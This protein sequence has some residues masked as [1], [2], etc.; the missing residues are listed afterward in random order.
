MY[1]RNSSKAAIA[2][3]EKEQKQAASRK[4]YVDSSDSDL[5]SDDSEGPTGLARLYSGTKKLSDN[6]PPRRTMKMVSF[7][8]IAPGAGRIA[9]GGI[10]YDQQANE[11]AIE[12]RRAKARLLPSMTQLHKH[13]LSWPYEG[14]AD[15]PPNLQASNLIRIPD[16][17][18]DCDEYI[19]TLE[20]LLLLESWAQFQRAKEENAFSE[21][22]EA[23][24]D[25]RM[26]IDMFHEITFN[27]ELGDLVDL[28]ENDVVVFA[29]SIN[30]DKLPFLNAARLAHSSGA[31][32]TSKKIEERFSGRK[33]FL[34][35]VKSRVFKRDSGQ[36]VVRAHFE[37]ARMAVFMNL[38]VMRSTWQFVKLFSATPVH[39]EYA[40]LRALPYLD[41]KLVQEVLQPHGQGITQALSQT[42]VRQCMKTH[43]LNQPQAE[44]VAAAIKREHG[45]TLIQGP[46][47][48]GK[49]KTILGLA[50]ALLQQAK[51]RPDKSKPSG[52]GQALYDASI[53]EPTADAD[54]KLNNKLLI[55]APSNAA[56]DEIVKRLKCGIRDDNGETFF[57][58]VV[59][60]G[61]SDSISSTVRDTT[62]D[63][64]LDK[65]LN[66]FGGAS[67]QSNIVGSGDISKAQSE[68]LLDVAGRSRREG[69][70]V[71]QAVQAKEARR[72]A[73]ET[74]RALRQKINE[75]SAELNQYEQKLKKTDPSNL[76]DVREIQ[77]RTRQALKSK[78]E[79][80]Q[81]LDAERTRAREA[82]R[83]MDATKHK[84]RLQILQKTDILCCTLS[85]S[86]H[87]LLTS[88]RCTFETVIIDEAAQSI[89]LSCLI[90]LKYGCERCILV[91]DPNQ[92]P[93]TVLSQTAAKLMYNQSMFVRIQK[94]APKSV[95][96]LSIQYRMHPE[97]SVFPSRLFYDSLLKDG[98]EMAKKQTAPWHSSEKFPPFRFFNIA[99]G[100]EQVGQS[101]SVFNIAEV[102]AAIQLVYNLCVDFPQIHW[103]QRIGI[104]TPYKQQLRK[105]IEKFSQAFGSKVT[106]VIEFNT[107]D[108]FQGQ[109]KDV[110]IFSC[111]R[112]GGSGV[113]FLSDERRMN[114]GLTRARKSL[115][116]L[117]NADLLVISPLWNQLVSDSKKRGLLK[118]CSLP[119][120]D[121]RI[122][123]GHK[124][125]NLFSDPAP[126][127][128]HAADGEGDRAEFIMEEV[129]KDAL[130]KLNESI[131]ATKDKPASSA[132]GNAD[133]RQEDR[134][135]DVDSKR[136]SAA[137]IAA[138]KRRNL[139]RRDPA[140]P[141]S[142]ASSAGV[143]KRISGDS[144][145]DTAGNVNSN[146]D[147]DGDGSGSGSGNGN[148]VVPKRPR[149]I[150][151]PSVMLQR[152]K[153]RSSL[154]INRR[155]GSR[156]SK[157]SSRSRSR[158]IQAAAPATA[159]GISSQG[160]SPAVSG[161]PAP[162]PQSASLH[163]PQPFGGVRPPPPVP[164]FARKPPAPVP[165]RQEPPL[166]P[167]AQARPPPQILPP[168]PQY[169]PPPLSLPPPPPLPRPP[170]YSSTSALDRHRGSDYIYGRNG[171]TDHGSSY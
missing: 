30:R 146:G 49:T 138:Q 95:N 9:R 38:L 85:G 101:H 33:T 29:E 89:E 106:D 130:E 141:L 93:P 40:A 153:Q 86:G 77:E 37:G 118:D 114:V 154:F 6:N 60:V 109:E 16:K 66:S 144:L 151:V 14:S 55:C 27:V 140:R 87:E 70:V 100:R 129:D 164:P 145:P 12:E 18:K 149:M 162:E 35:M 163:A 91:G 111:V 157:D 122:Q 54:A 158:D 84:V 22:G 143:A 63:F 7:D 61:Q 108:G 147:G 1:V 124:P 76:Q 73:E 117:G 64:L 136:M 68:M 10:F 44:A 13:L 110:I 17:F 26:S 94:N 121:R 126:D 80:C 53:K 159:S 39:R 169:I 52:G 50:G 4:V 135:M 132:G 58:R 105:L 139:A 67:D 42:A 96:L 21:V 8:A 24:L 62:L 81:K 98:P 57:P 31:S 3:L 78:R 115:F 112:A 107:V 74:Q 41:E 137:E 142:S 79:L 155:K 104:I 15:I 127:P 171:S 25:T 92:L 19:E 71:A 119:L 88:L 83:S 47:G 99:S 167:F 125:A 113:G 148:G 36:I 34:G 75:M 45:F 102:D 90:P 103:R 128:A 152:E 161:N 28:A 65:A 72:S 48:T 20:P 170:G 131:V 59:R 43:A 69:K 133:L 116:V 46:P 11:R 150:S 165:F 123:H 5:S 156:G 97:I 23:I 160:A 168:Q 166:P 32:E 56:V 134:G 82:M 2:E 51:Q 120:F